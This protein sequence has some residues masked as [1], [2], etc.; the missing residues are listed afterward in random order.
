MDEANQRQFDA[1]IRLRS[2]AED[3]LE[4]EGCEGC[5]INA[6]QALEHLGPIEATLERLGIE[7]PRVASERV[8]EEQRA[9]AAAGRPPHLRIEFEADIVVHEPS[10]KLQADLSSAVQKAVEKAVKKVPGATLAAFMMASR[11]DPEE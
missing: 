6:T 5:R 9:R 11:T 3:I 1:E 8:M 10:E 7:D 2:L 4:H